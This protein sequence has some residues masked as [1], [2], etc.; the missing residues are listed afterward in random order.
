MPR[1]IAVPLR[2]IIIERHLQGDSLLTIARDL[3]LSFFS[4][5]NIWRRYRDHPLGDLAP[6]YHIVTTPLS[7]PLIVRAALFLK[8]R[9]PC[10][11]AELIRQIIHQKW[12]HLP[13]PSTAS[14]QR[15]FR[16]AHLQPPR[17]KLPPA[18]HSRALT[19]HQVWQMDAVSGVRL[20]NGQRVCWLSLSD[21]ASGALLVAEVFAVPIWEQVSGQQV[22][23]YLRRAFE[24]WGMPE[25]IR[26][27]NGAPWGGWND[28]PRE[29]ALW[30]LG[31]DIEVFWNKPHHPQQNGVVERSHGVCKAWVEPHKCAD[32]AELQRKLDWAS[33]MQRERYPSIKGQS[34]LAA[35]PL[36]AAG[37]REYKA[38]QEDEQWQQSSVQH[39]LSKGIWKRRVSE[40]GQI[41][42]YNR[43]LGVGR[44][45]GKQ[46]VQVRFDAAAVAWVIQTED[47]TAIRRHPAPELSGERIKAF[48]VLERRNK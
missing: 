48:D 30:L 38:Q 17:S 14:F 34:R 40:N 35:Y 44:R 19:P 47:G 16:H 15:W 33:E 1:A 11:G 46:I 2:Q 36:L 28:L 10:W 20:A 4:V 13:L 3:D 31:L 9:H 23:D 18:N 12:P 8:R 5:R 37:G 22:A 41:T 43:H 24:R 39:W 6:R 29:L 42:M 27:D 25:R 32:G 45:Y 26:V 7:H 21:E